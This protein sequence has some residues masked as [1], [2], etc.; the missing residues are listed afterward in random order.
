MF[1]SLA[2]LRA[3]VNRQFTA[4]ASQR[5]YASSPKNVRRPDQGP[6]LRYLFLVVLGS[7]G[8]LHYCTQRMDKNRK[9]QTSFTEREFQEYEKRTG[10]RRRA[11][12][13][14][15]EKSDQYTFYAVPFT[16]SK[17]SIVAALGSLLLNGRETKI[18]DPAELMEKEVELEGK[19]SFLIEDIR[20]SGRLIPK[21]LL[22]ALVKNE[23]SLFMNTTK[24]QYDTNIIL[25]NYPQSTDEAIKFE[26]DISDIHACLVPESSDIL[27]KSLDPEQLRKINNV[28]GYFDTVHKVQK[29]KQDE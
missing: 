16:R 18:I 22:T 14:P 29:F 9:P 4:F 15:P 20:A 25:V 7:Y 12:I 1:R 2:R 19:Y 11:K 23:V 8:L 10:L 27:E 24:G 13:V 5:F 21:G 3:P 6:K 17:D 28:V 26:N